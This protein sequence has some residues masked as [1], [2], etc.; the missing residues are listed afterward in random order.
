MDGEKNLSSFN[1]SVAVLRGGLGISDLG[2]YAQIYKEC[3]EK[4]PRGI[5]SAFRKNSFLMKDISGEWTQ[6]SL[7]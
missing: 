4:D 3:L 5:S 7:R 1:H 2:F 6:I